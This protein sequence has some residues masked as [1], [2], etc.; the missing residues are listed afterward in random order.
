MVKD[1]QDV[2]MQ[3]GDD[4]KGQEGADGQRPS[5]GGGL[6]SMVEGDE[7]D[8]GGDGFQEV[9]VESLGLSHPSE[10]M[11]LALSDI[12]SIVLSYR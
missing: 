11:T 2:L 4:N 5:Q 6:A 10:Q 8:D 7:D 9:R 1:M 12:Q 3:S